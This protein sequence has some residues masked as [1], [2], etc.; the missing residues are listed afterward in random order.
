ML[1]LN[2]RTYTHTQQR[3]LFLPRD[4]DAMLSAVGPYMLRQFRPSLRSSVCYRRDLCKK[5]GWTYHRN[6]FTVWYGHHSSFSSP[7]VGPSCVNLT[8]SPAEYK[9]GS[10]FRP[11][12]G[13]ISETVRDRGIV[14]MEDEY[15]VVCAL[16]NVPLPMS[17]S[18][19]E[20]QFQGHC[21]V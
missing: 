6:F 16:S 10:D 2:D 20:P 18:D 1:E 3:Q 4:G 19:P 11:K 14:T 9:G 17:L 13:Y 8:E 7:R 15:K 21:I 12:C 5:N